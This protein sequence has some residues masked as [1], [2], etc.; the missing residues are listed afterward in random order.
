MGFLT[1]DEDRIV[2]AARQRGLLANQAPPEYLPAW[3]C[4]LLSC[5]LA[6]PTLG[7]SFLFVPILWVVQHEITAGR[8]ARLRVRLHSVAI[9]QLVPHPEEF[10]ACSP[11]PTG[12]EI[13]GAA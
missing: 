3:S 1:S 13:S 2:Q 8:I 4:T 9:G 11:Q 7:F 10:V 5:L 6:L 12:H